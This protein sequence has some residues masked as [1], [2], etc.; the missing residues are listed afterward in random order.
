MNLGLA[1]PHLEAFS[2]ARGAAASV[3]S[4]IKRKSVI[5]P[6]S[7]KGIKLDE[8]KG[9]LIFKNV[10]FEYPNRPEVKVSF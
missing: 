8:I 10:H 4:I 6:L 9:N 2:M 1:S 3:F 5:D 7:D